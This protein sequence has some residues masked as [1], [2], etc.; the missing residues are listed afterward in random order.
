MCVSNRLAMKI[1]CS[2]LLFGTIKP[3][4]QCKSSNASQ[5]RD[6]CY[7]VTIETRRASQRNTDYMHVCETLIA[8]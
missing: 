6:I 8:R 3:K 7:N 5:L 1:I 2:E 4:V